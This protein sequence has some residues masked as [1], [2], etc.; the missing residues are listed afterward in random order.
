V[1]RNLTFTSRRLHNRAQDSMVFGD[2]Q[3]PLV[4][5]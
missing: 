2:T 3:I 5:P 1:D 4:D